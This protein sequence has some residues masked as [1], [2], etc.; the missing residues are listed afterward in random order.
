MTPRFRGVPKKVAQF[1]EDQFNETGAQRVDVLRVKASTMRKHF[2]QLRGI[3][4]LVGVVSLDRVRVYFFDSQGRL[5]VGEN[6]DPSDYEKVQKQSRLLTSYEKPTPPTE[7]ELRME[8][9]EETRTILSK[10]IRKV[11]R[12][13]AQ[14]EPE[15]PELYVTAEETSD[16]SQNFG[17]TFEEDG[18][19]IFEESAVR[20][21]WAEGVC[22]RAAFLLLVDS[23]KRDIPFVQCIGNGIAFSHIGTKKKES[24]FAK[25]MK[26]S[27]DS[28]F[29]PLLNH[30]VRH[31]QAY[32]TGGFETIL[33]MIRNAPQDV[34]L[35][36]WLE[37]LETIHDY[38]EVPLETGDY[39]VM[40]RFCQRIGDI[41]ALRKR[42]DVLP[43]VHLGAR[44]ICNP[45][46]LDL[47]LSMID[48]EEDSESDCW[49]SVQYIHGNRVK[50][51]T[52]GAFEAKPVDSVTYVLNL[53]DLTPKPGG[54]QP[55]MKDIVR[56]AL[57]RLGLQSGWDG[58]FKKSI[59]FEDKELGTTESAVLE[60]LM[61]G[62]EKILSNTLL[63]SPETVRTL[64]ETGCM[65][66][67]PS[68]NH[69]G[70]R[71]NYLLKGNPQEIQNLVESCALEATV[72]VSEGMAYSIVS[73]PAAYG[74]EM[75]S[76][77]IDLEKSE[78]YPL[79][80]VSSNQRILRDE[81]IYRTDANWFSWAFTDF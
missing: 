80:G 1:G 3:T 67:L 73:C 27:K 16:E 56:W 7:E 40:R 28:R 45:K 76:R 41:S 54:I 23:T 2:K 44:A 58:T 6:L 39:H 66:L 79:A 46:P 53:D 59:V 13:L 10:A 52:A 50:S 30:L 26:I 35:K 22:L 49:L 61:T 75:V 70:I 24:W 19:L 18:A 65:I 5:L 68:F 60:R 34:T 36:L 74:R 37:G 57:N 31:T 71:P 72:F 77:S 33:E 17:M 48:G 25:W 51:L 63:G 81:T 64:V 8:A 55:R 62:D 38:I 9:T 11:S 14:S 42:K 20:T 21:E 69:L 78:I 4:Y 32:S 12:E 29:L 47:P 15:F 43:K